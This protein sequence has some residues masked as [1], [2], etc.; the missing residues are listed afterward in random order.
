VTESQGDVLIAKAGDIF[1]I[2]QYTNAVLLALFAA[3]VALVVL[4]SV[5]GFR[6]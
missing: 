2:L 5:K 4:A 3:L 6:R 1:T